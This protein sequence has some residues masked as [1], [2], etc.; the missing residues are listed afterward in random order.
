MTASLPRSE[1]TVSL[2]L[3]FLDIKNRVRD[4]AL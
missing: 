4:L 2:I 1:M 3:P